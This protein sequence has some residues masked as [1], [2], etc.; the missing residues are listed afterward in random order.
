M[1]W[2]P[3]IAPHATVMNI[4]LHIGVPDGCILYIWLHI[5]GIVKSGFVYI[6]MITPIAIT[7]RQIP[8]SGYIFPMI[9]SIEMN[10]AIK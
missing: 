4:K 2:N 5:S 9:L 7:I 3:D 10:V 1:E 8:K 6:P